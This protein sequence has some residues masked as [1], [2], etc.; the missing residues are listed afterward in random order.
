MIFKDY[1]SPQLR[2]LIKDI[3]SFGFEVS[4]V[5][6]VVRD[7]YLNTP[8]RHDYDIEVSSKDDSIDIELH[9]QNLIDFLSE[10]YSLEELKFRVIKVKLEEFSVELTLPRVEH[11]NDEF[12]HS[13]FTVE[14]VRDPDY[15]LSSLRR[16]F[17]INAMRYVFNGSDWIF[18]DPLDGLKDLK[19]K[20]LT[21][22]SVDFIKDPVRFLRVIRFSLLY[23]FEIDID[24]KNHFSNLKDSVFNSFYVRSE[25]LKSRAPLHFL[26]HLISFIDK[27]SYDEELKKISTVD[28]DVNDLKVHLR[29]LCLFDQRIQNRLYK[30]CGIKH[31][32][33]KFTYPINFKRDD[34]ETF[35]E[36]IKDSKSI[37]LLQA[38]DFHFEL[39]E[40]YIEN[41][42]QQKLIDI[43]GHE[44][45]SMKKM[46]IVFDTAI[47]PKNRK[48]YRAF[49]QLKSLT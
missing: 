37:E 21:P 40:K 9:Y 4:I 7:F 34:A 28:Q 6:G 47:D 44:F 14:Y 45:I 22:C 43:N 49:M 27:T 36:F 1:L 2:P 30:L 5:G 3:H 39:E 32:L 33:P 41:L 38:I 16:D 19:N 31:N 13:N 20:K 23:E 18:I 24:V 17:T 8:N 46:K 12:S 25:S 48:L 35:P 11:F 15:R 29:A 26:F 10:K 42:Y